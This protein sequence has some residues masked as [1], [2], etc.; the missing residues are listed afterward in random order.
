MV[1]LLHP[2]GETRVESW[3]C[4]GLGG[5]LL[6]LILPQYEIKQTDNLMDLP[7]G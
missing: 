4:S 5:M 6:K 3:N 1:C 2:T 7:L